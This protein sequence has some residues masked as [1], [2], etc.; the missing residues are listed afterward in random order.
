MKK[1]KIIFI[2]AIRIGKV[3]TGGETMKNKMLLRRFQDIYDIVIAIDTDDWQKRPWCLLQILW[4]LISTSYNIPVVVSASESSRWLFNILYYFPIKKNVNFWV[5]GG[6]LPSKINNGLFKLKSLQKLNR[7]IVEGGGMVSALNAMGLNN[8]VRVPNFKPVEYTPTFIQKT[9]RDINRFVFLSRIHPLKGIYEIIEACKEL[10]SLGYT[11]QFE[12]DFFGVIETG[13][14]NEFKNFISSCNN[15]HYKGFLN[16]MSDDGYKVL[17]QYDTMLFPT[18][19]TNEGFPGIIIDAYIA[20]V[21]I[22]ASDWNLN[23]ELVKE[24]QTGFVIPVHDS[25]ALAEKM[26]Q[27]IDKDIDLYQMKCRCVENA[28]HYDFRNVVTEDLLKSLNIL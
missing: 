19:W 16:L 23:K 15:L 4:A 14:E 27:I 28:K 10:N 20:G 2:G 21:P 22:I 6:A 24:G 13:Y 1:K 3:S 9:K 7:I 11:S 17:S 25:S 26:K 12:I 18:Y 8:V 5:I